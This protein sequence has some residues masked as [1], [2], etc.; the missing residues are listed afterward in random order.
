MTAAAL[1]HLR[2]AAALGWVDYRS[3]NLDP[4]F[5]LLRGPAFQTIIDELSAKVAD[6]RRKAIER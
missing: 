6:M 4:R 3:L 1:A 2:Q 5:D